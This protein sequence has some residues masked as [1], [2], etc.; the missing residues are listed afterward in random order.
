MGMDVIVDESVPAGTVYMLD[1]S[2]LLFMKRLP[3]TR[4]QRLIAFLGRIFWWHRARSYHATLTGLS[5]DT[6]SE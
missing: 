4:L 5:A 1:T 3:P 6:P 2:R